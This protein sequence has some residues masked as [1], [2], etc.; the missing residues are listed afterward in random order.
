[1]NSLMIGR[2]I[3]LLEDNKSNTIYTLQCKDVKT[4]LFY[5]DLDYN[6]NNLSRI[7]N[8]DTE[9]AKLLIC[10]ILDKYCNEEYINLEVLKE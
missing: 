6:I 8:I 10:D 3:N 1:M 5:S 9:K 4:E 7:Y 2:K